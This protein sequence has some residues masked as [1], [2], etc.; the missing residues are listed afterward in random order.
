MAKIQA[1][2]LSEIMGSL[3]EIKLF[4]PKSSP[5]DKVDQLFLCALGFQL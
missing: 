3:P 5:E 4:T 2:G 1:V